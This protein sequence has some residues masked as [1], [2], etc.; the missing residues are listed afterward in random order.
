MTEPPSAELEPEPVRRPSP[1]VAVAGV[2][3]AALVVATVVAPAPGPAGLGLVVGAAAIGLAGVLRP[4]GQG[5]AGL[6]ALPAPALALTLSA[7][8]AAWSAVLAA[9][10]C[11]SLRRRLAPVTES[12]KRR[13][14]AR[15]LSDALALGAATLIAA[16]PLDWAWTLPL[17]AGL[18]VAAATVPLY[19]AALQG[20]E[21]LQRTA[22]R[23]ADETGAGGE[24]DATLQPRDLPAIA[25]DGLGWALGLLA[26][27]AVLAAGWWSS[28]PLLAAVCALA[29][30][31]ARV[32][33]RSERLQR[34]V[35]AL[36]R[37]ASLVSTTPSRRRADLPR[38]IARRVAETVELGWLEIGLADAAGGLEVHSVDASGRLRCG[39]ATPEAR[40]SALPGIHRRRGWA[41]IERTL[42]TADRQLGYLRIW[43]DPRRLDPT[44]GELLEALLQ[45][46]AATVERVAL[47]AEASQDP[48]TGLVKRQV[49]EQ[50]LARSFERSRHSGAPLAVAM[51]DLDRFKEIN[52]TWGHAGGD[53]VL[54]EVAR[55]LKEHSRRATLCCR[56]GGEEFALFFE[57]AD[58]GEALAAVDRLR[59][60]VEEIEIELDGGRI[61]LT[62]SAG[63]AAIPELVVDG[64]G[65]LVELADRALYAAKNAGRNRSLLLAAPGRYRTADGAELG[66]PRSPPAAPRL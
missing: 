4:T 18:A 42:A 8:W 63:V 54:V 22:R 60:A 50:R 45:Q 6:A 34:Q 37:V 11:P 41:V 33:G 32:Q 48:L 51:I 64:W 24:P 29:L 14:V 30:L 17:P 43:C 59:A 7:P 38:E 31:A 35:R 46:L 39:P 15:L 56:Y 65:P 23:R 44:R 13:S 19:L 66:A 25:W 9:L 58:G 5:R 16:A 10:A 40:P 49:F 52:D 21:H 47:D 53:R 20:L 27:P 12:R 26:A 28:T 61:D 57:D 36:E 2:S 1:R 62:L 3:A 55:M